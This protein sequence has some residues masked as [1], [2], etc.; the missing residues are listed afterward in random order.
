MNQNLVLKLCE[1][2]VLFTY[3]IVETNGPPLEQDL[4]RP[5]GV[6]GVPELHDVEADVLVEAVEDNFAQTAVVPR[7]V[8]KQQFQ[9]EP[10]LS[11]GVITGASSLQAFH[12]WD[13]HADMSLLYHSHVVRSIPDRQRHTLRVCCHQ[14]YHLSINF[15]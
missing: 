7:A 12:A 3:N 13:T 9:Q 1:R 6:D 11:D 2:K 15:Q 5:A 14:V 10:E 4:S 8:D